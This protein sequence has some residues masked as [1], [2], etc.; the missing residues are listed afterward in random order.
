MQSPR[1]RSSLRVEVIDDKLLFL[2]NDSQ[3]LII[4]NP[5]AV[6]VGA[7]VDGQRSMADIMAELA[8]ELSPERVFVELRKLE[9]TGAITSGPEPDSQTGRYL[10]M[11]GGALGG[12]AAGLQTFSASVLDLAG[13]GLTPALAEAVSEAGVA[14]R[15]VSDLDGAQVAQDALLVVV[16][17]DYLDS[18]LEEINT[19]MQEAGRS[20]MLV[21]VL[22]REVWVGPRMVPGETGC[23]HCAKERLAANRQVERYVDGKL[24]SPYPRV[25][26]CGLAPGASAVV[27]GMVA[28][29]LFSVGAG[30]PGALKGSMRSLDLPTLETKEHA[31]I[32]LPQC[33]VCGD[34]EA[35]ARRTAHVPMDP[36]TA[37]VTEDG[38]YRTC[39]PTETLRRLE[40][41]IS[42][43]LG[44]VN[45]LLSLNT[46]HEGITY[47]FVAGHNFGMVRDSIG[48][49]KSNMRGQSGGKGRTEVQA[50][51]SGVCEALERFS[52]VYTPDIP[53]VTSTF[54]DLPKRG[55]NPMDILGYSE[56]QYAGRKEWNADP[57]NRLQQ[58]PLKFDENRE[59]KFTPAWS[60]T[61]QEE[62]LVPSG[63]AWFGHPDIDAYPYCV[64]DSNG[65]AAGNTL[66]EA[67]L[68][69]LCEVYERDA[70]A[71]WWFNRVARPGVDL[72]SFG[73][74]YIAKLKAFYAERDRD[75][76]VIDLSNDLTAVRTFG[77]FSRRHGHPV[78]D[79]MMGFGAHPDPNIALF[80]ALT[81]LNQF[82]PFVAERDDE[83]N[84]V[85]MTD[86]A[87][88]IEWC[89]TR[90]VEE[91]P[92]LLPHPDLPMLTK[93][94]LD[95][96]QEVPRRL[97]EVVQRC[98]D[99]LAK[100]GVETIVVNQTR[101]DIELA[102]AK[103]F[104]PGM[105]HFWKRTGPGRLY[106]VP[107]KLGWLETPRR[108]DELNPIGMFF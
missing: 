94:D 107:V 71:L 100:S 95:K 79:I 69:G 54:A 11:V 61:H 108:E 46:D 36:E 28:N 97:D 5:D 66:D 41:H 52:G 22:G 26:P 104:C 62:V 31:L 93:Q 24:G 92:W 86:D 17:E 81:E 63:M 99:D 6:R 8:G 40:K 91:D 32:A 56:A 59:I 67:V 20:W 23:W 78:Q 57:R 44:A 76:W 60:L 18:R 75:V 1:F 34:P 27:A 15:E 39:E 14:V 53:E 47:S 88:T 83:G 50:K 51:V 29:E 101:P 74:D 87:A 70:V 42:P 45:K 4:E 10:D 73:S 84:T 89:S 13:S 65:G 103:V 96:Q 37:T 102:V 30:L 55:L 48:L 64:A 21:K 85:Y 9:L 33:P 106:D 80:R 58:V 3:T 35:A 68:Q 7:L 77:A 25:I 2:L 98:V 105:R 19:T 12:D 43:Y 72:D 49:L 82:L 90:T 16:V 38:G